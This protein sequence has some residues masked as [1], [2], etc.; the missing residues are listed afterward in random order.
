MNHESKFPGFLGNFHFE[1][2]F[3]FILFRIARMENDLQNV[4]R[5]ERINST[6]RVEKVVS[7]IN[8]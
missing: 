5:K 2:G 7:T 1:Y 6:G 8:P 3:Y 4:Q